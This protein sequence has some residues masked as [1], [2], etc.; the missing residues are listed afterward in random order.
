M[1]PDVRLSAFFEEPV[2]QSHWPLRRTDEEWVRFGHLSKFF[3]M[4]VQK[5]LEPKVP[6]LGPGPLSE[7]LVC[8]LGGFNGTYL[9]LVL[10][11]GMGHEFME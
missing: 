11:H 2:V 7:R 8:L 4:L 1:T 5:D 3:D 10:L 6:I 9:V